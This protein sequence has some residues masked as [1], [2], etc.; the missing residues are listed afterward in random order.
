MPPVSD[1]H[2]EGRVALSTIREDS[3]AIFE[4]EEV[5]SPTLS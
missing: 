2:F 1:L 3:G 5:Y 4:A